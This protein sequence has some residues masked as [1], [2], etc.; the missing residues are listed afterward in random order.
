MTVLA[1]STGICVELLVS[2]AFMTV[3]VFSVVV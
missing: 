2:N 3:L 1:I